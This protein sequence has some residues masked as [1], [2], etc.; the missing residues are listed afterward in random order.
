MQL[1]ESSIFAQRMITKIS[2]SMIIIYLI[3][4]LIQEEKYNYTVYLSLKVYQHEDQKKVSLETD[5]EENANL[6]IK[7]TEQLSDTDIKVN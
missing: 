6:K 7:I 2:K 3:T 4:S 5:M 1:Q